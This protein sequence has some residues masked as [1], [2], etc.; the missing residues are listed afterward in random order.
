MTPLLFYPF[1]LSFYLPGMEGMPLMGEL[2][3]IIALVMFS[4]NIIITKVASLRLNLNL[5][6]LI[7]LTTNVLFASLLFGVQFIFREEA[8]HW[9]TKGFFLFLISG[10]F[11]TYLGRWFFF[12]T[13]T[14]LGPARASN[15]QISN[16]LFTVLIAWVFLGEQLNALDLFSVGVVLFGL[17]LVSYIPHHSVKIDSLHP[18]TSRILDQDEVA[19][20]FSKKV[21]LKRIVQSGILIAFLSAL[22][23]AISNV[24]RGVA[25]KSW[26]EPILGALLGAA[27]GVILHLLF[28][29]V[30]RNV[31]SQWKDSDRT[32][33]ILYSLSGVLTI[34]AQICLITS[35]WYI[36][37]SIANLITLSTPVLVTPLSY[38]FLKNQ[39][40]ITLR[41]V[42]GGVFILLGIGVIIIK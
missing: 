10:F 18:N 8:F 32:A 12:A 2:L 23:Y 26:N 11:A 16:P 38:F 35:M 41:T 17:F 14:K 15:F 34:T 9:N 27:L 3:A 40:G 5:G 42:L 36:P 7:S 22:S 33:I 19:A 39:E 31:W 37:V 4:I 30:A 28:N 13:I 1:G 25:I 24:L 6:F 20:N 21:D 29:P